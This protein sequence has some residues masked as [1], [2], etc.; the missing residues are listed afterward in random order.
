MEEKAIV[1]F[2][3]RFWMVDEKRGEM[4]IIWRDGCTAIVPENLI[5]YI[6]VALPTD[7]GDE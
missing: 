1:K 3:D 7:E 2:Q 6:K 4:L 5:K